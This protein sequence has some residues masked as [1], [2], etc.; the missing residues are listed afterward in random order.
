MNNACEYWVSIDIGYCNFAILVAKITNIPGEKTL[1][2]SIEFWDRI[3]LTSLSVKDKNFWGDV[4]K[5]LH[6]YFGNHEL[7]KFFLLKECRGVLIEKQMANNFKASQISHYCQGY[8]YNLWRPN[9]MFRT[10]SKFVINTL[11]EN[12]D[13]KI[14]LEYPSQF[15]TQVILQHVMRNN[16]IPGELK[17]GYDRKKW[18]V[19]YAFFMLAREELHEWS[20]Y[21]F[22]Q[23]TTKR[24]DYADTMIQLETYLILKQYRI[25][26]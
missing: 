1:K 24:D 2:W 3:E 9:V 22:C 10:A 23:D 19:D 18:A 20:S 8:F 17:S 16:E 4:L 21:L 25:F 14:I 12:N 6:L 7:E 15:K 13:T 11:P 26:F 5:K